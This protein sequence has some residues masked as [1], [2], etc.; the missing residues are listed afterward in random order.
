MKKER[1]VLDEQEWEWELIVLALY[2]SM[3][4][5]EPVTIKLFDLYKEVLYKDIVIQVDR[6]LKR[7][8]LRWS[9]DDWDWI[10]M[11]E[12]IAATY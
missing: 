2:H 7:I 9:D 6:K 5:H 3:A 12:I 1:P 4:D 11:S 8:K 10:E